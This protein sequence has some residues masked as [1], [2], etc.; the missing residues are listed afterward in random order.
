MKMST[1]CSSTPYVGY[2]NHAIIWTTLFHTSIANI[3]IIYG[4]VI[5]IEMAHY[6]LRT[7]NV[8]II[9]QKRVNHFQ[10]RN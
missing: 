9:R 8:L 10:T 6:I 2:V 1:R 5:A 7:Q 3:D 4:S